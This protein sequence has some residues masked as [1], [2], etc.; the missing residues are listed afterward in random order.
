MIAYHKCMLTTKCMSRVVKMACYI[1]DADE[2]SFDKA[3]TDRSSP[4]HLD[5][6]NMGFE[7]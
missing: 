7:E 3:A 6:S 4:Q 5:D 1:I 2:A